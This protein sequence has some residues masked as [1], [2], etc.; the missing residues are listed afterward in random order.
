[1][2]SKMQVITGRTRIFGIIADP[3]QQVKTPEEMNALMAACG[4]DR[5]LVPLHVNEA[6]LDNAVGGLRSIHNLDGF[7]VTVPHKT[8]MVAHCD[9]LSVAAQMVGAVNVVRREA[10]GSLHG[11]ILDGV[12]FVAGL[13]RSG[14]EAMGMSVYL[15]GAGGAAQ[16]IAFALAEA[17][18]SRITI[19]NRTRA[20]AEELIGRLA[21][22][23]ADLSLG[24]GSTDPSGHELVVNATSMGLRESDDYPCDVTRLSPDQV[25]AEII[26]QPER[27]RLIEAASAKGCRIHLGRPMLQCQIELMA[28]AMGVETHGRVPVEDGE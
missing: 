22:T 15:C 17:G 27:T 24:V 10:D 26:M 4:E 20:K 28:A 14:I 5:V 21:S 1:M 18:V 6:F 2:N 7:I 25:V 13:R 23:F 8:A 11:D 12:G 16:A 19:A 3:I 9:S